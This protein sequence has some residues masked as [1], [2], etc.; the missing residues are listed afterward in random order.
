MEET[1]PMARMEVRLNT[2][3]TRQRET[4][5]Q[6]RAM[7]ALEMAVKEVRRDTD[8]NRNAIRD[9]VVEVKGLTASIQRATW[10]I[11]GGVAVTSFFFLLVNFYLKVKA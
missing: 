11:T 7:P 5:G 10:T 4:E 2:V 6:L 8:E 1:A 3:E 9:L